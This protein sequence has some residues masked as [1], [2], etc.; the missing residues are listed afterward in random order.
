MKTLTFEQVKPVMH[1]W[2]SIFQN[3]QFEKWELINE[4]WLNGKVRFLPQSKI[5]LASNRIRCDMI[6]YMRVQSG[7][8]RRKQRETKGILY[9]HLPYMINFSEIEHHRNKHISKSFKDFYFSTADKKSIWQTDYE[10]RDFFDYILNSIYMTRIEKLI[11]KLYYI[12]CYSMK[13]VG[14][15]CGYDE[16][17]ISQLHMNIIERL[18][19]YDF[20]IWIKE[21]YIKNKVNIHGE[22]RNK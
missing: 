18:R 3:N 5:K 2:A 15:I 10:Q 13:E 4:A 1:K 9:K 11:M 19:A 7:G 22:P 12:D 14:N 20:D 6:D 17:R 8:R 21:Q 16:S